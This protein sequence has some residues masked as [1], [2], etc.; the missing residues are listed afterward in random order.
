M[1]MNNVKYAG[2]WIRASASLIDTVLILIVIFPLLH[3]IYGNEYWLSESFVFGIW[4][5]ILTYLFPAIAVLVFWIVKSATPGKLILKL[6]IVDAKSGVSASVKQLVIRY[7]AYYL[8]AI[9]LFL[10]FIWVGIDKKKQGF[11]DKI[12]NTMVA[13]KASGKR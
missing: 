5:V 12:S 13:K 6:T 1:E 3:L 9:P 4:D 11:H 10:G 2:F 7:L 8:S